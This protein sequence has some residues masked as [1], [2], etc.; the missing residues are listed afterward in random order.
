MKKTFHPYKCKIIFS[1]LLVACLFLFNLSCGLDTYEVFESPEQYIHQPEADELGEYDRYFEFYTN[2]P[3]SS[4]SYSTISYLGTSVYYKIYNSKAQAETE[5][6]ILISRSEDS[7]NSANASTYMMSTYAYQ[8]LLS[9]SGRNTVLIPT[10]YKNQLV[11][12]RLNNSSAGNAGILVDGKNIKNSA[13]ASLPRR[14]KDDLSFNFDSYDKERND[15]RV[16]VYN[17]EGSDVDLDVKY[18][19]TS[20][21][22]EENDIQNGVWYVV[23]FAV[24]VAR[25]MTFTL[26]Y[27]N[28]LYLGTVKITE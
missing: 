22:S 12:I 4:G 5:K 10:A 27:S 2:E 3:S 9:S 23:M 25:D 26:N 8:E 13:E 19:S 16:K 11:H 14:Y 17:N 20:P 18:L 1:F 6:N 15:G 21:S 7:E 24:G 28:I